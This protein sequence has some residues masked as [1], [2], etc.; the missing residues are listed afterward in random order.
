M[1]TSDPKRTLR[2][3]RVTEA[4]DLGAG[5]KAVDRINKAL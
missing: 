5:A 3:L 4:H 1:P 2:G